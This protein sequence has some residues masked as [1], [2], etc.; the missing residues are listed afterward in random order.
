M[1]TNDRAAVLAEAE[2]LVN[3][4]RNNSYG[5]PNQDFA[6]TAHMWSAYLDI[7]VS[8]HDV[9]AM[10]G[11]LK[12]SRIRWSHDKRDH[13]VDLAGYAACGWDCVAE[14]ARNAG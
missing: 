5:P 14:E 3:G 10:M 9:A 2:L 13:W 6:R 11:M 7:E 1:S 4:D 12:L 8:N